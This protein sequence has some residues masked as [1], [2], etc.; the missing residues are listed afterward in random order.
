MIIIDGITSD[1]QISSFD[2]LEDILMALIE[3]KSLE[4]RVLTDI[5]I[6]EEAFSELYPHQS[7][8]IKSSDIQKLEICSSSLTQ[9]ADD[10][11]GE[12]HKVI[13]LMSNGAQRCAALFRSSDINSALE[14]LQDIIDVSRDFLGTISILCSEFKFDQNEDVIKI[15]SSLSNII[16]E[17]SDLIVLEDWVVLSDL[18]EFEFKP[19]CEAWANILGLIAQEIAQ[20]KAA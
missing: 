18:V 3:D 14:T 4:N 11:T 8:D 10:V 9:M 7:E 15:S 16:E 2:N 13:T 5:F 20:H 6:N 12:L 1:I 17:M 19:A